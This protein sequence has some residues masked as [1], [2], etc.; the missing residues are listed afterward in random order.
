[1]TTWFFKAVEENE[2]QVEGFD[3]ILCL[4]GDFACCVASEERDL[5]PA[6][7]LRQYNHARHHAKVC[8]Y[9]SVR[10]KKDK[11]GYNVSCVLCVFKAEED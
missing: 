10:V 5:S 8:I 6:L 2:E 7:Y 3:V 9:E 11:T 1:M 4:H